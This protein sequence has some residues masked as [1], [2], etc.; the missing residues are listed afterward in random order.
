MVSGIIVSRYV[1]PLPETDRSDR[2][3]SAGPLYPSEDILKLLETEQAVFPWT[4]KCIA[5]V[6]RLALDGDD[7]NDLLREAVSNGRFTGS[8]W[9]Q[10]RADGPWA[11]CDAY[12]LIRAEWI[13]VARKEIRMEYYLKLAVGKTGKIL[14]LVSCHL[15]EERRSS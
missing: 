6:Q 14:L 15:S 11:A 2:K 3:I 1:G 5:D 4:K 13:E 8:E 9:C 10:Q 7:L 12:F